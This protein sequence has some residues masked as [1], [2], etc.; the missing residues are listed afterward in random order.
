M[1]RFWVV[2]FGNWSVIW[3]FS[4]WSCWRVFVILVSSD[5]N[6]LELNYWSFFFLVELVK[7]FVK[8]F[9]GEW[10]FERLIVSMGVVVIVVVFCGRN[11]L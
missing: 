4:D 7:V 10:S 8:G 3:V 6:C 2:D 9:W 1:G 5:V 11:C